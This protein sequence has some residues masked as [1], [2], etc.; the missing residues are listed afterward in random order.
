MK[1]ES[2][3]LLTISGFMD[4]LI[5]HDVDTIHAVQVACAE[6]LTGER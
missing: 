5:D 2:Y 1:I 4:N 6:K 3:F